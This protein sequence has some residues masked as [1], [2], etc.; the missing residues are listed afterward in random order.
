MSTFQ[1][2]TRRAQKLRAAL[3]GPSGSGKTL[4]ALALAHSLDPEGRV[5]V[6][7]TEN[8]SA[9]LYSE[10]FAFDTAQ[11][12]P[13]YLTS[14]Y[15]DLMQA[16]AGEGYRVLVIDS[17]SPQWEGEGGILERKDKLDQ[18]PASNHWTNWGK[19]TPEINAFRN[20]LLQCPLHLIV[21][22]RSKQA[23]AQEGAG[24]GARI[25]KLGMQPLQREG[26]E[27]EFSVVFNLAMNHLAEVGATG[28]DRTGLFTG[29]APFPLYDPARKRSPVGEKLR[30][31]LDGAAPV[32]L[33]PLVIP[34]GDRKGQPLTELSEGELEG[35]IQW[36]R[37]KDP[38]AYAL[39]IQEC[40]TLIAAFASPVAE[41][42]TT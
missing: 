14:K 8:G 34:A 13:P 15:L 19:M 27:Y 9:S 32:Q 5:V 33:A 2:A 11:I 20:A 37:K 1:R 25:V 17:I 38:D 42:Q 40:F 28:K 22:M 29:E 6:I 31:W 12:T 30:T 39:V 3:S 23:Y 18:V 10:D 4:G 7:D 26:M 24:K 35:V 16:A 21:T 41:G 36:C